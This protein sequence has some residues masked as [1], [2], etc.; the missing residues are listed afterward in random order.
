M[1]HYDNFESARQKYRPE[2]IKFLLIAEAPPKA[3]S[4]RFFYFEKVSKGDSLFLETI[5]VLY[6][7]YDYSD[8]KSIR[9]RKR[10]FLERFKNDGFYLIDASD[11][12]MEDTRPARKKKQLK[13]SLPSLIQKIES[14]VSENT[15]IVLISLTVYKVCYDILKSK[16]FNVINE[17]SIPF[18]SSAWQREFREKLSDLLRNH[19]WQ[20]S[21][22][23]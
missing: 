9:S 18:P 15:K 14:L 20:A 19:G 17:S 7:F 5:K 8:I 23:E 10:E 2:T 4:R 11:K 12:P 13:R 22:N 1:K 6:P 16:G 21:C 3:E